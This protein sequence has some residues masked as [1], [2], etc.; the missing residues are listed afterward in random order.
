M[1][2]LCSQH[3]LVVGYDGRQRPF[4]FDVLREELRV[5][6]RHCGIAESWQAEHIA[7]II[8]EQIL[9][10]QAQQDRQ[11]AESELDGMVTS[12][13]LA[14]GYGDVAAAYRER[15]QAQP[16]EMGK[17]V[18]A[19]WDEA[20]LERQ[21]A[22]FIPLSR[23]A[24]PELVVKVKR[25]LS[26]LGLQEVSDGLI[27]ELGAHLLRKSVRVGEA[28]QSS[29]D[30]GEAIGLAEWAALLTDAQ[31]ELLDRG[32]VRLLPIS[33]IF[34]R[35]RVEL[36]LPRVVPDTVPRPLTE[37]VF[38]PGLHRAC[39]ALRDALVRVRCELCQ[40]RPQAAQ[41]PGHLIIKGMEALFQD[42]LAPMRRRD[43]DALQR[44]VEENVRADI[45]TRVPFEVTVS[46]RAR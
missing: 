10:D 1:I 27:Q 45:V 38:L 13:L 14:S 4:S 3:A 11:V 28:R 9:E 34:P 5:C 36:D 44:E 17:E 37:M 43:A 40:R 6:F 46:A 22:G 12:V 30:T 8:E 19:A 16:H 32:V 24:L 15:R 2:K 23:A 7:L 41:F 18:F 20:R 35:A 26:E 39:D 33:S 25:A 31:R 42:H 29:A 21:L